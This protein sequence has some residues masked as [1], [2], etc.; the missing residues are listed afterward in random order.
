MTAHPTAHPPAHPPARPRRAPT[1]PA[2]ARVPTRLGAALCAL[3][4][5]AA[6]AV[7][8][9]APAE[10]AAPSIVLD[11]L[12]VPASV[13]VG[14]SV[15][16]SARV[17]SSAG[18][19]AVQAITVAVRSGSGGEFDFPGATSATVG[20]SGYTFTSGSRTF[21]A[22]GTY[23]AFVAVQ[24]NGQWTNLT[25]STA[26][27]VGA[28][29]PSIV[30]DSLS[31]PAS[32]AVGQSVSASAR[33]HSS[34]GSV[35][36]QAITVA[37]RSG[38]GGEFDFP[39]ATSAT[40]GTSGYTFTS[41]S[42]TFAAAGTYQAFVAVQVNGQWT[43]LTPSTAITVG[44][45]NPVT[46]SQDFSGP[47]GA[48]PNQGRPTPVWFTDPC[49]R[50][51]CTGTIAQYKDDH[52]TLD[53]QG[54]LVLTADRAVDSGARCGT[55]ACSYATARLTMRDWAD[56]SGT[57]PAS[58]SQ[59]GGHFEARI[60]VSSG[61]GLW[62][63]FW[64]NGLGAWPNSGEIDIFEAFGGPAREYGQF[65]HAG[66]SEEEDINRGG[67][68]QLASGDIT[69]WHVYAVDW[70]ASANGHVTWS[71][72]GVVTQ[73]FTAAELGSAW[74]HLRQPQAL[75]LDL[76]VGGEVGAP[77]PAVFPARMA[78]DYIT[79]NQRPAR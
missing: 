6:V 23:Q 39:G 13:A 25:P 1:V 74:T 29:A 63:A 43:N 17:H 34:A 44:A 66:P 14:Q 8:L 22:A 41:G 5:W 62:P 60:K 20:T 70:D 59:T 16:A 52:A 77:D 64:L 61:R 40:V 65:V 55:V 37:V 78:I 28:A 45:A 7:A 18:S 47:A 68:R 32:V 9:A 48:S 50:D 38:S 2:P 71:V 58:W 26:I 19:V 49:W 75:I 27:T 33:V 30:L 10:A 35:A 36:V 54:A 79:V 72:D 31:V 3:L 42:R 73:S 12:S 24:V 51:G 11:S 76:A 57:G 4:T 46:F 53:G 56:P 69:G 21:A 67:T 15:S